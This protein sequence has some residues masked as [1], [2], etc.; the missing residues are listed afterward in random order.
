[1]KKLCLKDDLQV[2][3]RLDDCFYLVVLNHRRDQQSVPKVV[4]LESNWNLQF[5]N[6]TF[7]IKQSKPDYFITDLLDVGFLHLKDFRKVFLLHYFNV[8]LKIKKTKNEQ[9]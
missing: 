1:M 5:S 3:K 2:R 4:N 7:T 9:Q 6:S 8:R